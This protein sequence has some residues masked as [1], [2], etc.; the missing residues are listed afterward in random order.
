MVASETITALLARGLTSVAGCDAHLREVVRTATAIVRR[1]KSIWPAP[2]QP[3][4][5]PANRASRSASGADAQ[6]QEWW[7]QSTTQKNHHQWSRFDSWPLVPCLGGLRMG[8][9]ARQMSS[10]DLLRADEVDEGHEPSA[11]RPT[12]DEAKIHGCRADAGSVEAS[13]PKGEQTEADQIDEQDRS[14]TAVP[15]VD[16]RQSFRCDGPWLGE[17]FMPRSPG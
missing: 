5:D 16:R 9:L 7:R 3:T 2:H 10:H 14:T 4:N 1:P 8:S 12:L 17:R 11:E 15:A 13:R 6:G